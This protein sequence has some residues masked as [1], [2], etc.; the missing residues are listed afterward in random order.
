M[1]PIGLSRSTNQLFSPFH[2]IKSKLILF[3]EKNICPL[4]NR[5][6]CAE[7]DDKI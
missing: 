2:S 6:L 1:F 7:K 4:L 3:L 5:E